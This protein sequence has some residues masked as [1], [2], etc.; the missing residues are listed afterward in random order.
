M[1]RAVLFLLFTALMSASHVY[2]Q[3]KT[4]KSEAVF[5]VEPGIPF[6]A[7]ALR[8]LKKEISNASPERIFAV[9]LV[10]DEPVSVEPRILVPRVNREIAK[11]REKGE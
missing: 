8:K 9:H 3:A 4:D 2:A 7:E 6:D 1:N 5:A 11:Q 10:F